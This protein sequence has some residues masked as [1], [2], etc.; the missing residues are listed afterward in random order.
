MIEVE[1]LS[2]A[3]ILE[4]LA[5]LDYGHLACSLNDQPYI[6]PIH[7]AYDDGEIYI[8]TTEGKKSDILKVNPRVSLQ[9]EDVAD[10]Q[11]WVSVIVN[12]EAGRVMD[13]VERE[14]ALKLIVAINPTLTPAVSVHWMDSWVRENIE[15][16]YKIIPLELSGR[17]AVMSDSNNMPLV[18]VSEHERGKIY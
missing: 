12:G 5:R 11:N 14:K 18:A 6:V 17:R 4:V 10:N 2:H 13:P 9:A 8:Y 1:E 16:I 7:Y 3:E 15:V